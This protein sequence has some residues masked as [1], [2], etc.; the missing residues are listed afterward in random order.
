MSAVKERWCIALEG[1]ISSDGRGLLKDRTTFRDPAPVYLVKSTPEHPRGGHYGGENTICGK[2]IDFARVMTSDGLEI[3][4]TYEGEEIPK[5]HV[6]SCDMDQVDPKGLRSEW[7]EKY[8]L[9]GR[10][11]GAAIIDGPNMFGDRI[12]RVDV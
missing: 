4:A 2:L 10:I 12:R 7:S 11:A 9:S 8:W 5:D 3:H 1:V 6:I